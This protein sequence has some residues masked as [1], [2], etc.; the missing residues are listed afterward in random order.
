MGMDAATG[1]VLFREPL[2]TDGQM[3]F[4]DGVL[5]LAER[6]ED[7]GPIRVVGY[8]P[9]SGAPTGASISVPRDETRFRM[10]SIPS[11]FLAAGEGSL[12]I[13][14][15]GAGEVIRVAP[16]TPPSSPPSVAPGA[17]RFFF[18]APSDRGVFE[19]T[20]SPPSICYSTQSFPA[21]PIRIQALPPQSI[22]HVEGVY[23]PDGASFC[24]RSISA[25]LANDIIADPSGYRIVWHPQ[26]GDPLTFT[27]LSP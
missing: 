25:A 23:R 8:D 17:A 13:T 11:V 24:D 21:R 10:M 1:D 19:V 14:D 9:R 7:N 16:P 27:P 2:Q 15:F 4:L 22:S 3:R 20:T 26:V 18:T 12:W 6:P 5:W